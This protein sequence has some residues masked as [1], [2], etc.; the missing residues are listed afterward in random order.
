MESKN[1]IIGEERGL[2]GI[3]IT[4]GAW[5]RLSLYDGYAH[6]RAYVYQGGKRI[7]VVYRY[8]HGEKIDKAFEVFEDIKRKEPPFQGIFNGNN[9]VTQLKRMESI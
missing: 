6:F 8:F 5:A 9:L 4:N 1:K 3:S 2:W 7:L